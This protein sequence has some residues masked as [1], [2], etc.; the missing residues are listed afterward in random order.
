MI[1]F[2]KAKQKASNKAIEAQLLTSET[3]I[4]ELENDKSILS[5]KNGQLEQSIISINNRLDGII[6]EKNTLNN[7][8]IEKTQLLDHEKS[9]SQRLE[10]ELQSLKDDK[11]ST[12]N[13][14]VTVLTE[15]IRHCTLLKAMGDMSSTECTNSVINKVECSLVEYGVT[16]V[17]E[18]DEGFDPTC[19]RVVSVQETEDVLKKNHV[20]QVVRPGYWFAGKC[21]IP[22]DVIVFTE[23]K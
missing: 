15:L 7:L 2:K 3:R 19:Q 23:K 20:A 6:S 17:K 10:R 8:L 11:D 9:K 1:H 22:Q 13:N 12:V 18:S 4:Q 14:T 16:I 5:E 21:L